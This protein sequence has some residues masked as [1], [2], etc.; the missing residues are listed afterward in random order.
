MVEDLHAG[1][2]VQGAAERAFDE[3]AQRRAVGGRKGDKIGHGQV[4][5]P[6]VGVSADAARAKKKKKK[7]EPGY[8]T[9]QLSMAVVQAGSLTLM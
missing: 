6:R 1:L 7:K 3:L 9:R 4:L 2:L 8:G 5:V